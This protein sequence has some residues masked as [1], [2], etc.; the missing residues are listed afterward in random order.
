MK[1]KLLVSATT[2]RTTSRRSSRFIISLRNKST[3]AVGRVFTLTRF[4]WNSW[5][6]V[7]SV[8]VKAIILS[9]S[10]S[11]GSS[12][13]P[14][15]LASANWIMWLELW[16]PVSLAWMRRSKTKLEALLPSFSL[17]ICL[18]MNQ[19]E[20]RKGGYGAICGLVFPVC[21]QRDSWWKLGSRRGTC[22]ALGLKLAVVNLR[23]ECI[24]HLSLL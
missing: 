20:V 23:N 21:M 9:I 15:K 11:L 18:Q 4:S 22:S 17:I 13:H 2:C 10:R 5:L 19:G 8:F 12:L 1:V 24:Q 14:Y 16:V 6:V 3:E 7:G